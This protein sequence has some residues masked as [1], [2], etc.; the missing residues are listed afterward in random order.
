MLLELALLAVALFFLAACSP[1][2]GYQ[3]QAC[4]TEDRTLNLGFYAHFAPVSYSEATDPSAPVSNVHQG[5]EA[6]LL[7]AV[8]AMEPPGLSF[9]RQAITL[10]DGIW[11]QAASPQ[12]DIVGGG[13]TILDSRTHDARDN[14]VVTFTSGH[15]EFRQSLLVRSEDTGRLA[16]YPDLTGDVRVGALAS[17]TGEHRLLELVGLVDDQGILAA[18]ARVDTPAGAVVADGSANYVITAAG[19]SPNLAGRTRLYPPTQD[20]PQVV[21]LGDAVGEKELLEALG[22]G[23]IDALARGE[24]GNRDATQA[25]GGAFAVTALDEDVEVGGFALAAEDSDLVACLNERLDWLTD[26]R[27]IGYGEWSEDTSV[28]HHRAELW[29]QRSR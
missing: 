8:E 15:I 2:D 6:D 17:T 7:T 21:Y 26:N 18:G 22:D 13:I 3:A 14:R 9:N 19:E 27:A 11:L 1:N 28:F 10:W 12:Y 23:R 25:S 29:N 20:K 24:V 16:S 5:Y 4:G